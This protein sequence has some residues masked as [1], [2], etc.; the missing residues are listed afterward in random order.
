MFSW[1]AETTVGFL[2]ETYDVGEKVVVA[3]YDDICDI[4]DAIERGWENGL[5]AQKPEIEQTSESM[6][7]NEKE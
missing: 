4:P 1:I 2:S 5:S 6:N 7:T 3:T